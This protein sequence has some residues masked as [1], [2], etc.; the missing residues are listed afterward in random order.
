MRGWVVWEDE[1]RIRRGARSTSAKF[2]LWQS[3]LS[4]SANFDFG[5]FLVVEFWAKLEKTKRKNRRKTERKEK[6]GQSVKSVFG[7]LR[8]RLRNVCIKEGG[9]GG[10]GSGRVGYGRFS[11]GRGGVSGEGWGEVGREGRRGAREEERGT[12]GVTG[13][14]G[15]KVARGGEGKGEGRFW[16]VCVCVF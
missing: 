10:G 5:Q 13:G 4:S 8:E 1:E 3:F 11:L 15:G 16:G 12:E 14:R 7:G 9:E 6:V 2:R